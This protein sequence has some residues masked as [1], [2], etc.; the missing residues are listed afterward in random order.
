MLLNIASCIESK[1]HDSNTD[2]SNW[3]DTFCNNI[4]A[5]LSKATT[6]PERLRQSE[7][8]AWGE[9]IYHFIHQLLEA[10]H[11]ENIQAQIEWIVSARDKKHTAM[12]DNWRG[13]VSIHFLCLCLTE[14]ADNLN[15]AQAAVDKKTSSPRTKVHQTTTHVFF[16]KPK[17][18]FFILREAFTEG[19]FDKNA[20][21]LLRGQ[22]TIIDEPSPLAKPCCLY[23]PFKPK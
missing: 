6:S 3:I 7:L 13:N 23:N 16:E 11:H 15:P 9:C 1:L 10:I 2:Y 4:Q 19:W 8:I 14:N 17:S 20:K 21:Q 18:P 12:P 5:I 22:P